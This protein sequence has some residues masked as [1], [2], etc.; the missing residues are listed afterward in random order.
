MWVTASVA[1]LPAAPGLTSTRNCWPSFSDR[2]CAIRR[3]TTRRCG[4]RGGPRARRCFPPDARNKPGRGRRR[5][6]ARPPPPLA[7]IVYGRGSWAD[8]LLTAVEREQRCERT[9]ESTVR[10]RG[11]P[12]PAALTQGYITRAGE[13]RPMR[14][15]RPG[16]LRRD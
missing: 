6:G 11:L 4:R 3:A 12:L 1:M 15:D 8:P 13:R 14:R 5:G 10:A 2:N 16:L 9:A 7:G